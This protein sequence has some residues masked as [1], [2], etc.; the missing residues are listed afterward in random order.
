[1]STNKLRKPHEWMEN[2]RSG[3]KI[4]GVEEIKKIPGVDDA[5]KTP[6]VDDDATGTNCESDEAEV[7][8]ESI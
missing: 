2:P 3:L 4:P 6:G 8:E 5:E 1:M 7:K